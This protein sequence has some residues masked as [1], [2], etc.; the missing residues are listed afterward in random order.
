MAERWDRRF[1]NELNLPLKNIGRVVV[2]AHDKT[3]HDLNA[4]RS[5]MA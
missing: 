5:E 2:E 4:V 1:A 3:C